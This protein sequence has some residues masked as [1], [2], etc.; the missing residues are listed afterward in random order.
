MAKP[1]KRFNGCFIYWVLFLI[2]F[3]LGRAKK[4]SLCYLLGNDISSSSRRVVY[5]GEVLTIYQEWKN[6]PIKHD[7]LLIHCIICAGLFFK[8]DF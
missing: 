1:F 5:G 2:P 8:A 7:I 4:Y 3:K 6:K